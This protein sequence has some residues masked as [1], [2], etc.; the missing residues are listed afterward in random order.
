M[1]KN[2]PIAFSSPDLVAA[3]IGAYSHIAIVPKD[4]ELIVLA[5]QIGNLPDGTIPADAETQYE[6][7]LNNIAKLL[8]SQKCTPADIVKINTYLVRPLDSEKI[9]GV[10]QRILGD[11]KP[12][13][14]M[15]YVPRLA[16]LELLI[17]IEVW[18]ARRA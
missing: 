3:P 6:N 2:S 7:A 4:Y 10:R 14:T 5:G 18:A 15:V 8:H 1:P 13:S 9:R 17:E 16:T 11:V 12:P